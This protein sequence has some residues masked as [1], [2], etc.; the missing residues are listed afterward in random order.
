MFCWTWGTKQNE[1]LLEELKSLKVIIAGVLLCH[2]F[3]CLLGPADKGHWKWKEVKK[4]ETTCP[5]TESNDNYFNDNLA[6]CFN[7]FI[8]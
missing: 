8:S 6:I 2:D 1:I 4:T 5:E 3:N 7:C